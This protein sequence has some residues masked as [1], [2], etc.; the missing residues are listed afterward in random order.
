MGS[1]LVRFRGMVQ[2]TGLGGELFPATN[3]DGSKLFMY[4][5]WEHTATSAASSSLPYMNNLLPSALVAGKSSPPSSGSGARFKGETGATESQLTSLRAGSQPYIPFDRGQEHTATSAA[6]SS[7][8]YMNNL[9][10]SA[11]V[12]GKSS[13]PS[14]VS[15]TG[16]MRLFAHRPRTTRNCASGNSSTSLVCREKLPGRR[17]AEERVTHVRLALQ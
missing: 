1:S 6:S 14:P 13:P 12:A 8:P 15:C 3:A 10:P 2:D 4:G 5:P 16:L 7:L 9:L 11:L 17:R